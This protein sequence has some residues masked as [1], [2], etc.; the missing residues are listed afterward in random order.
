MKKNN[1]ITN[2][3]NNEKIKNEV[4]KI[5]KVTTSLYHMDREIDPTSSC[6]KQAATYALC[7]ADLCCIKTQRKELI[8]V[9]RFLAEQEVNIEH[10]FISMREALLKKLYDNEGTGYEPYNKWL[11]AEEKMNSFAV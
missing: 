1:T 3:T 8:L 9:A 7:L 6:A 5:F 11:E 10:V 4:T 2:T